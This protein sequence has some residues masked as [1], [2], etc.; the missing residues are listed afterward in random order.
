MPEAAEDLNVK[1][2]FGPSIKDN[3]VGNVIFEDFLPNALKAGNFVPAPEPLVVG[4]GLESVQ[5]A[6]DLLARGC[7]QRKWLSLSKASSAYWLDPWCRFW[8]KG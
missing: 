6:V 5:G 1:F 7:L 3:E 4:R 8:G 2:I